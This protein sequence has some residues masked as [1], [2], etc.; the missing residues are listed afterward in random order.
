[1]GHPG[2]MYGYE[3]GRGRGRAAGEA[4]PEP[5]FEPVHGD[6]VPHIN[7]I[8]RGRYGTKCTGYNALRSLVPV[9]AHSAQSQGDGLVP[10]YESG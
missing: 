9:L 3:Q 7:R 4:E 6:E 1:M 2:A 5:L 8:R 10:Q